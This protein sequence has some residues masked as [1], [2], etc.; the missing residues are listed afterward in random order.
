MFL[1]VFTWRELKHELRRAG[2]KIIDAVYLD[3]KRH[4]ALH[5]P[6]LC[7]NLRANGWIVVCE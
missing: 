3:P 1:H 7:G 6:W 2:F 5:A 4:R